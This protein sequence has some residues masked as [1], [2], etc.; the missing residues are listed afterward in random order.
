MSKS[1]A[2][3][4]PATENPKSGAKSSPP[5]VDRFSIFTGLSARLV[6]LTIAFVMLAE[7]LIWAPSVSRFRKNYLEENIAKAHL[8]MIAVG[9]LNSDA[10][11]RDLEQELLFYTNT[12]GIVLNLSDQRMLMVGDTMPP[13]IDLDV[14]L[15]DDRFLGWVRDSFSTMAQRENRVLRVMGPS[16]K[17]PEIEVEIIIDEA[18]MRDAMIYYSWRILGLSIVISMFTAALV[19]FS[20]QWLMVRPIRH[21]TRN[22]GQFREKP[23]DPDRVIKP[24]DRTDE[25]GRAQRELRIM[26]EE[27]RLALRQKTRLA[28]LGAAVARVNHD[29]RNTLATAVLVSDRLSTID[30]PEVQRV[31]P[32]LYNAMDRAVRLCSQTLDYVSASDLKLRLEPFHLQELLTEVGVAL[33]EGLSE[34][35]MAWDNDVAFEVTVIGDRHQLFR[36]FHNLALNAQMAGAKHLMVSAQVSDDVACIDLMDDG[37]GLPEKTRDHLFEPFAGSSR[38]GGT[39]LGLVIAHDI[40]V[41]HEGQIEL[42]KT[43]A[44]GTTF[45][46]HLSAL[47]GDELLLAEDHDEPG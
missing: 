23:E 26:Q 47:Q 27:V 5:R 31:M 22:L 18:P 34:Q 10:V 1:E 21:L 11:S 12:Y 42:T 17:N 30:D 37:P 46:I 4:T 25:L 41:A 36:A 44:T 9:S 8:A 20:L 32:R 40:V 2:E 43:D 6:V 19:F 33:R 7:F 3:N 24:T 15:S 28:T 16:P 14:D 13:K 45:R 38:K 35:T 29:L 39:G